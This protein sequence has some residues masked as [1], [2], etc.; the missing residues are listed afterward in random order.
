M[1]IVSV[2]YTTNNAGKA[3]RRMTMEHNGV[4]VSDEAAIGCAYTTLE[5]QTK[6]LIRLMKQVSEVDVGGGE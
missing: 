3:I 5:H 6:T 2:E 4:T 1:K